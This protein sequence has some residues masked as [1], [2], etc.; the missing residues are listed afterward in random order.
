LIR[1][2]VGIED[3]DDLK[4]DLQAVFENTRII[5]TFNLGTEFNV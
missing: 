4:A 5:N 1:L 2:S 3:I